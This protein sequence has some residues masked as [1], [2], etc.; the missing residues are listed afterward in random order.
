M[1]A[2]A[3]QG[4]VEEALELYEKEAPIQYVNNWMSI[5]RSLRSTSY[6]IPRI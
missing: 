3:R 1:I 5:E 4:K 6:E 2:L